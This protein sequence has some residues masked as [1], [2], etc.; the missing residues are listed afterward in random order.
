MTDRPSAPPL[1]CEVLE[2]TLSDLDGVM[3]VMVDSFDPRFGEAWTASQC[4]SL[5]P[6]PGVWM[7][8]AKAGDD[9]LGFSMSRLVA[10]EAELLLLAVRAPDQ[11]RGVG[12]QLLDDFETLATTKGADRLHLEVRDGNKAVQLYEDAG[13]RLIGR[14]KGYYKGKNGEV[15]DAL[16]L[17]KRPV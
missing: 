3:G 2:G 10:G 5:L 4:A 16:T 12:R 17:A 6:M 8:V 13:F 1:S 14:R 9:V 7:R 15:F 11:G